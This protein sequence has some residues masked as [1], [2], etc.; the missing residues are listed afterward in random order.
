MGALT[1]RL[2]AVIIWSS[3]FIISSFCALMSSISSLVRSLVS[4][5]DRSIFCFFAAKT[6]F[7]DIFAVL[8]VTSAFGAKAPVNWS[9]VARTRKRVMDKRAII[10]I[11]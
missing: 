7:E 11:I 4:I 9:T 2:K 5:E 1:A 8:F 6:K 10:A 3:K